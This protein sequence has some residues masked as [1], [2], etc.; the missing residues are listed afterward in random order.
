MRPATTFLLNIF[1]SPFSQKK[2][3]VFIQEGIRNLDE[4]QLIFLEMS[5]QSSPKI[6]I[7]KR[8]ERCMII[9]ARSKKMVFLCPQIGVLSREEGT[10]E[11][12]RFLR[13]P[14]FGAFYFPA[15]GQRGRM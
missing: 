3:L 1:I 10:G 14:G 9:I 5:V 4:T 13:A 11:N 8:G 6:F 12:H 15:N 2:G 7:D